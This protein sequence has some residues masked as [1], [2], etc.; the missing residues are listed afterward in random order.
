MLKNSLPNPRG[1]LGGSCHVLVVFF[2]KYQFPNVVLP[3]STQVFVDGNCGY[4]STALSLPQVH[5]C[6]VP[7]DIWWY[8]HELLKKIRFVL[9]LLML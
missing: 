8:P 6:S 5:L 2:K 4:S 3:Q 7:S 1:F 9:L